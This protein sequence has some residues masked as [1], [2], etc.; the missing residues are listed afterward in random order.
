VTCTSVDSNGNYYPVT[1]DGWVGVWQ[2]H[3][4]DIE[5]ASL[6]RCYAES[7]GDAGCTFVDCEPTY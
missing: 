5:D 6:N 3:I 4:G 7:N 1:D 2:Q